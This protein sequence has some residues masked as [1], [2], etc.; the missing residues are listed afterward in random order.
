MQANL[1]VDAQQSQLG[2]LY[3]TLISFTWVKT[4]EWAFQVILLYKLHVKN[5][6]LEYVVFQT[7]EK[8]FFL[9]LSLCSSAGL[10]QLQS[11]LNC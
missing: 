9:T 4:Q 2:K 5:C 3:V 10:P 6:L 7:A 8:E 11:V 1:F